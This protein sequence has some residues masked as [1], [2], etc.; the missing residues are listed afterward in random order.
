MFRNQKN[1]R[2]MVFVDVRNVLGCANATGFRF[3]VDF[4]ALIKHIVGDRILA[5]VYLFDG[6]VV[7]TDGTIGRRFHDALRAEGLRVITRESFCPDSD[8]QKEVD[9]AMACEMLEHAI[10]DHFDTAIVVS[11]DR[12]FLPAIE[13]VQNE[14]KTV[15]LAGFKMSM[16]HVLQLRCDVYHALDSLPLMYLESSKYKA[17]EEESVCSSVDTEVEIDVFQ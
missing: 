9:V 14:G 7:G 16:S 5:G 3:K 10:K 17:F 4:T 2:T 11:G 8:Q 6:E 15:E 12:D 13:K 1:E